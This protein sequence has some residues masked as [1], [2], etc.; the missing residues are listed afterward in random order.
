MLCSDKGTESQSV[1]MPSNLSGHTYIPSHAVS[2]EI[3]NFPRWAT[4]SSERASAGHQRD[5][6]LWMIRPVS[7]SALPPNLF[8]HLVHFVS[9]G[10]GQTSE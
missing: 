8:F 2:I 9:S 10:C 5:Y 4:D 7:L 1:K 6:R 3:E